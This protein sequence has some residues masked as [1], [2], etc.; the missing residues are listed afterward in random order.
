MKLNW[1]Y[2]IILFFVIF[3]SIMIGFMIFSFRQSNDLVTDDYYE[4][5]AN[6]TYQME[7]NGRSAPYNDSIQIINLNHSILAR[8]AKSIQRNQDT[9]RINF[10]RASDKKFDYSVKSIL[11]SDSIKIEKKFLQ[12]GHYT[13]TFLWMN[14]AKNYQVEKDLFVE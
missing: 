12:K 8:F 5:G 7:I 4:K 6:Y 11:N 14:G 13:V 1:G 3:C 9:L 2:S 10:Y